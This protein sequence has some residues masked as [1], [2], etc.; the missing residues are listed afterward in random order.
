M[1]EKR[2][3]SNEKFVL[4][5]PARRS[6]SQYA[7]SYAMV[8]Q[9]LGGS[10]TF[11]NP[12]LLK[13]GAATYTQ[14]D[15]TGRNRWGDYSSTVEDPTQA[16]TFW[17]FQEFASAP[18]VWSVQITELTVPDAGSTGLLL[19]GAWGGL[20]LLRRRRGVATT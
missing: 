3:S 20:W 17:T 9:T 4:P 1:L 2:A 14:L 16:N 15:S 5:R 18:N 7:S 19:A 10:T 13:A 11:G 12:I 6:A 8:G